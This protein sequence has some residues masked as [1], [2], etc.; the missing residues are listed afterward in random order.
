MKNNKKVNKKKVKNNLFFKIISILLAL[1]FVVSIGFIIY[2]E[3]LPIQYLSMLI[4][5]GG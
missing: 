5:F 3:L 1:V 4:I 2:F